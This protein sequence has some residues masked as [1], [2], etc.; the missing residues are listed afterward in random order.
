MN[1]FHCAVTVLRR[2]FVRMEGYERLPEDF[3][4]DFG[5]GDFP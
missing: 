1:L 4:G 3:G 2:Y 5:A